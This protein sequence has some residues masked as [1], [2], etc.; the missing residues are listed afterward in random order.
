MAIF[1]CLNDFI[2]LNTQYVHPPN[3][4]KG[5]FTQLSLERSPFEGGA[6]G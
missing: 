6:G 1:F 2:W 3:P 5:E 4:S